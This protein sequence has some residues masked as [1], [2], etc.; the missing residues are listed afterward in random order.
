MTRIAASVP[1]G[2]ERAGSFRSPDMLAPAMIPVTAGKNSAKA[3][4]ADHPSS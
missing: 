3:V 2:I 1:R 4:T